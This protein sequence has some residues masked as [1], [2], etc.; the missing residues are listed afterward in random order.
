MLSMLYFWHQ[1][2]VNNW[3]MLNT[4]S[5]TTKGCKFMEVSQP[6]SEREKEPVLEISLNHSNF[7]HERALWKNY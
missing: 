7:A 2:S 6:S 3:Y 4:T 5:L 1:E